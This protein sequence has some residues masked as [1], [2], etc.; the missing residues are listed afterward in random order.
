MAQK[1]LYTKKLGTNVAAGARPLY[2]I[3][4]HVISRTSNGWTVVP[5]G[6]VRGIKV[7]STQRQAVTFARQTASQRHGEVVI[8]GKTGQISD[9]VSFK[10]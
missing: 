4:Y 1:S 3:R 10:K 2:P 9:L 7:F 8:H 6:S 5:E